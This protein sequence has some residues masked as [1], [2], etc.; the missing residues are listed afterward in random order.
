M[1]WNLSEQACGRERS[2]AERAAQPQGITSI[3]LHSF[4]QTGT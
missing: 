4:T 2:Q 3:H 1:R